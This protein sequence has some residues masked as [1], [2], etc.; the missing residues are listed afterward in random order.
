MKRL[1]SRPCEYKGY[2]MRSQLEGR[3]ARRLDEFDIKWEYEPQGYKMSDGTCYLPD[4]YLPEEGI[5]IEGKGVMTEEDAHKCD[6]FV[7][8]ND[9]RELLLIV[10]P[11]GNITPL[12]PYWWTDDFGKYERKFSIKYKLWNDTNERFA[13]AFHFGN[14]CGNLTLRKCYDENFYGSFFC[15]CCGELLVYDS[16]IDQRVGVFRWI[17]YGE[18][19]NFFDNDEFLT[20]IKE[21]FGCTRR[22]SLKSYISQRVS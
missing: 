1:P 2:Q 15:A 6:M 4:F 9:K 8:E 22:G 7:K 14:G 19:D 18:N 17:D 5:W 16:I 3:I 13:Y 11:D 20:F 21:G 12:G 10:S